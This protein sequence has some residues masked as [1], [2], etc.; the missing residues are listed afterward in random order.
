[1]SIPEKVVNAAWGIVGT[2]AMITVSTV[3]ENRQAI[4][5][6][7]SKVIEVEEIN[8][9][10]D[11]L[12]NEVLGVSGRLTL[13]RSDISELQAEQRKLRVSSAR[14][15]H[16]SRCDDTYEDPRARQDCYITFSPTG[17]E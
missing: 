12:N 2:L 17:I 1:M 7:D 9:K 8:N 3:L 13:V 6:L 5:I 16:R 4:A 15:D 11:N 10:L 14:V